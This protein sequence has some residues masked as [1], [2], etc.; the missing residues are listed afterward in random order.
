MNLFYMLVYKCHPIAYAC[1]YMEA[2]RYV[3]NIPLSMSCEKIYAKTPELLNLPHV[4]DVPERVWKILS[5]I[6]LEGD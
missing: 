3:D 4:H 5:V 1:T 2:M 6:D